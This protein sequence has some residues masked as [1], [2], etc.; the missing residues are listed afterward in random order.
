MSGFS[1]PSSFGF[2]VG[3]KNNFKGFPVPLLGVFVKL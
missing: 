1:S 3:F 2:H